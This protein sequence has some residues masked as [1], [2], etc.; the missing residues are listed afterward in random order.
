MRLLAV[1]DRSEQEIRS[2]LA[3]QGVSA[4]IVNATIRRLQELHYLDDR[5]FACGAAESA[6]RRGHGSERV[7]AELAAKGVAESLID[8]ALH[9]AFAD[10]TELARRALHRRYP[11]EPRQPAERARAARQLLRQGFPE[12]VVA[13]I[14]AEEFC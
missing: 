7:R 6:A 4:S 13:A 14:L 10:E 1:H 11:S 5:R 3:A 8:A 12:A 2:R 9:A